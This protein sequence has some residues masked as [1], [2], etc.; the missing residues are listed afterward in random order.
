MT[1]SPIIKFVT[2]Q[3]IIG[4]GKSTQLQRIREAHPEF[5]FVDEPLAVW[6]SLVD[7]KSGKNL[8]ELFYSDQTRW[9]YTFQNSAFI[10]RL[11]AATDALEAAKK[12]WTKRY[13]IATIANPDVEYKTPLVVV[14][15]RDILCDR[16]VFA[17][18]LHDS[19]TLSELEWKLYTSWFDYFCGGDKPIIKVDG[20]V[21][22]REPVDVCQQRIKTRGRVGEENIPVEYQRELNE[23]HE[24]WLTT[25]TIPVLQM[26]SEAAEIQKIGCFVNAL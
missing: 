22:V 7:P 24:R 25:T 5:M 9:A 26:S 17:T 21:W 12:E 10:T 3:G 16:H 1:P 14:S 6:Q 4:V 11:R 2:L 8:L 20:I 23:Y 13:T 15:E 18:M 19:N